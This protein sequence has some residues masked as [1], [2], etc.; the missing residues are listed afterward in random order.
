MADEFDEKVAE[1]LPHRVAHRGMMP[2]HTVCPC[3]CRDAV[4]QFGREAKAQGFAEGV[5]KA[6]QAITERGRQIGGAIDPLHTAT[7]IRALIPTPAEKEP[8]EH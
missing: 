5:E 4:A 6:A 2:R 3:I 1:L 7:A 8:N